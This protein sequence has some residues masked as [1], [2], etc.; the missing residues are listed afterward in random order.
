MPNLIY[1]AHANPGGLPITP[2]KRCLRYCSDVIR[3]NTLSGGGILLHRLGMR[4]RSV[5]SM[6]SIAAKAPELGGIGAF[7]LDESR[8]NFRSS[9]GFRRVEGF[10]AGVVE[11][12]TELACDGQSRPRLREF[13]P[14]PFANEQLS[15]V[16]AILE[17]WRAEKSRAQWPSWKHCLL[18]EGNAC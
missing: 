7:P 9:P 5:H 2:V 14:P 8:M 3:T 15:I 17:I 12:V 10:A 13:P 4:K 18:P 6:N 11:L 16:G 1:I